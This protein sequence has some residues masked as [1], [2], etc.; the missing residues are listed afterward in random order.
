MTYICK[1]FLTNYNQ[2]CLPLVRR[3]SSA[4]L[5]SLLLNC[6]NLSSHAITDSST[7]MVRV[8]SVAEKNDVAKNVANILG[9][10]AVRTR[11][12]LSKFNKVYEITVGHNTLGN[13]NMSLTSVCGHLFNYD[14]GT[15]HKKWWSCEPK[16]LFWAP[17]EQTCGDNNQRIK[18]TLIREAKRCDVLIIWT[19]CDREGENIGFE[20]ITVCRSANPRLNIF[21][22]HFSEITV[23]AIN[24][25]FNNL[26]RP[27]KKL[28]D[29]VDVRQ[30]LDLRLG[31]AFTR[32]LTLELQK[33]RPELRD[34]KHVVSYGSCQ[35][36]TLGFVVDRH[37]QRENFV[38]QKFWSLE[39][40]YKKNGFNAKFHWKRVR[41]FCELS[42]LAIMSKVMDNF[43]AIVTNIQ[44]K[45][46]TKWRP[47]PLDTVT[48][49]RSV[50][51][52]LKIN[53]KKAMA[54]AE[55]LYTNGFISY[56]RT[57]TNKFPPELNLVNYTQLQIDSPIW[58]QFAQ[59][60]LNNGP[61][62]RNGN[63]SDNAHPP[64]HPTKYAPNLTGDDK[65][66]YELIVRH[67][68]ACLDKDAVGFET[69][70]DICV[71]EEIFSLSGLRIEEKNYLEIYIYDKWSDKEIPQFSQNERFIP[72]S[73]EVT[74]GQTTAPELLTESQLIALMEK[75]GIGTDATHAEHIE[76]VKERKYI[77]ETPDRRLKPEGLG[78][79][80]VDGYDEIGY[81]M[82]KPHLRSALEK[83]LQAICDGLKN[84][85][86]VL[87][88]QIIEYEKVFKESLKHKNRLFD[89]VVRKL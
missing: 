43:E 62:P 47:Q 65:R 51:S 34:T 79:G 87:N 21:R 13:C 71:N 84:P 27:N 67:F 68:L 64:I 29:A 75:H 85:E 80:L 24:R 15:Q 32:F 52:K 3:Q 45:R 40:N 10:G 39:V 49:E 58:G 5:W 69:T 22:A 83:D 37:K 81:Q 7:S 26:I 50:S 53:A 61:N 33:L 88:N 28:A 16:D 56:P 9:R 86:I 55:K 11:E 19:D 82:S 36:P 66:V 89:A 25:A 48:F 73:I 30:K 17:I 59:R 4:S 20:V 78:I 72:D 35:F 14:F 31:A 18:Q 38:P 74:D 12:G 44:T 8:L 76:K 54:I 46:R 41:L 57:E 42:C 1:Q 77:T 60:I 70:I 63:K 23:E 6:R 2:K